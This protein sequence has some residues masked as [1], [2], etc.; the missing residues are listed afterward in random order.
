MNA[1]GLDLGRFPRPRNEI[2]GPDEMNAEL[3]GRLLAGDVE[4]ASAIYGSIAARLDP[5]RWWN[6]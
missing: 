2:V 3:I 4:G 1:G 6:G 5:R